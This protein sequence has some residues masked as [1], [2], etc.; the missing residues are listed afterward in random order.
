MDK[1]LTNILPKIDP[2]DIHLLNF[3]K[4][5]MSHLT[6]EPNAD[7]LKLIAA[8]GHFLLYGG[9]RS[10]LL[11][12]GYAGTGKTSMTGAIVRALNEASVKTVLLAPTGRA[13]KIMAE[14]S[15]HSA[16][17]IH[18]KIY[19][20]KAYGLNGT[21]NLADNKHTR[22][23]FI[24]DEAS[25]I[26]NSSPD[27]AVFGSGRLLDDLIS[28]VYSGENCRLML[29]GDAAQLPPVGQTASP[30]LSENVIAGYGL[31]VYKVFLS[32]IARQ[33]QQSGIIVNATA[34][35]NAMLAPVTEPPRIDVTHF[36]DT[37]AITGEFMLE[38]LSSC[39][40]Y[41]GT[42]D[43]I[44]ITRSNKRAVIYNAAIRNQILYREEELST[45]DM[46]LIAKNNYFWAEEYENL[47]F[48]AN[49]DVARV[50][51]VWGDVEKR[52]GLRFA[53][54]T[55]SLPY[56]NNLEMDVK[57]VLDCLF[58]D[59]P[60]LTREQN[61]H[62]FN[63]ALNAYSGDRRARLRSLKTDPYYNALQVKFAYALTCHK[64]QGGQ[65][66]NV[67]VDMGG[68]APDATL[69][70]DYLRW[71]Y[72]AITRAR[73]NVYLVNYRDPDNDFDY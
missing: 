1:K 63:N 27:G 3:G 8:F 52:H 6:Y 10:A 60:A 44:V 16:Y 14:Y 39:Y 4:A 66:A 11:L 7:Q 12:S 31:N 5:V 35:R 25:M 34:L 41:G 42:D 49:G 55:V 26:A 40:D 48:L 17:T 9:D 15:G 72:T 37:E 65:W 45:G 64:A 73:S 69:T 28:Y 54:V 32:E 2:N 19:R 33:A 61:E 56:H 22:T 38:M 29:I 58:S 13:A 21:F 70:I 51:K 36:D 47:D 71:L 57:I 46:L 24:V 62:L 50:E 43:T 23:V 59:A 53:D 18:R 68:I 30:A 20:Q 67:F